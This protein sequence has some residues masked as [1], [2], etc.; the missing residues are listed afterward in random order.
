MEAFTHGNYLAVEYLFTKEPSVTIIPDEL[1]RKRWRQN[2]QSC[3]NY[4]RLPNYDSNLAKCI[5]CAAANNWDVQKEATEVI[6]FVS[7]NRA[8]LPVCAVL[9]NLNDSD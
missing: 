4:L 7:A 2:L 1:R 8:E 6:Q 3:L 9:L 5:E